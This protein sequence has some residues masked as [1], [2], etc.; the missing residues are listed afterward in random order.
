[1]QSVLDFFEKF[2]VDMANIWSW[3]TTPVVGDWSPLGMLGVGGL[4]LVVV[5]LLVK[6]INPLS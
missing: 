3:L 1:M 4:C 2:I 5:C 6:L